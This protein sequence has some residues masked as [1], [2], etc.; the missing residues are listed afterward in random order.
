VKKVI[1][2]IPC[3]ECIFYQQIDDVAGE[4]RRHAPIPRT[5]KNDVYWPTVIA[6][7]DWCGEAEE[8]ER[9]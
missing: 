2:I 9:E 7:E 3:G 1:H 8:R 4:C 6:D 5:E